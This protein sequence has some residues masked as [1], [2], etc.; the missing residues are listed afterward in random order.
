MS[1]G[2]PQI[3]YLKL[4]NKKSKFWGLLLF[5]FWFNFNKSNLIPGDIPKFLQEIQNKVKETRI[6]D[7]EEEDGE[8]SEQVKP[9][10][11]DQR[12]FLVSDS[13]VSEI[14]EDRVLKSQAYLL[15]Y[16]RIL[17]HSANYCDIT[18]NVTLKCY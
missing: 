7:S 2:L 10:T 5:L 13:H 17:W 8:E 12:W 14:N 18:Y 15:F 1:S 6:I 9:K 11:G 3:T 4:L 16:E